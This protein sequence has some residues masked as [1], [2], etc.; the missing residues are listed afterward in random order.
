MPGRRFNALGR[1]S[2]SCAP[3][4]LWTRR[5]AAAGVSV[6]TLDQIDLTDLDFFMNGDVAGAFAMLRAEDPVHWQEKRPGRGFWS[7]TKFE[8]ALKIYRDAQNF[9]SGG[10]VTLHFG[11]DEEDSSGLGRSMI[12]T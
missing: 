11:T 2:L 3:S 6:V 8:D 9:K 12:M 5:Y 4:L 7:V 10:G 1:G